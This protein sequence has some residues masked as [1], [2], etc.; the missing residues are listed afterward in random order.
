MQGLQGWL[1]VFKTAYI[2]NH[3]LVHEELQGLLRLP[4]ELLDDF[5][6]AC[7]HLNRFK[8]RGGHVTF[9]VKLVEQRAGHI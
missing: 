6:T 3:Q 1:D 8:H 2:H 9:D 4:M 7:E 5:Y